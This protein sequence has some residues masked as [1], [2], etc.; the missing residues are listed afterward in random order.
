M[1]H[2]DDVAHGSAGFAKGW[3][4]AEVLCQEYSVRHRRGLLSP[5]FRLGIEDGR[6]TP[7]TVVV[8][9]V[10]LRALAAMVIFRHKNLRHGWHDTCRRGCLVNRFES[11]ANAAPV[12]SLTARTTIIITDSGNG[13]N[14]CI[15]FSKSKFLRCH[16]PAKSLCS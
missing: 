16:Y 12:S 3:F 14:R 15:Q 6:V 1:L 13:N 2:G 7:F 8:A 5:I 11:T 9:P 4:S 10:N